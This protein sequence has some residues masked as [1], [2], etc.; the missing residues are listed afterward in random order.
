MPWRHHYLLVLHVDKHVDSEGGPHQAGGARVQER[1]CMWASASLTRSSSARST[2][3]PALPSSTTEARWLRVCAGVQQ[4]PA[5]SGPRNVSAAPTRLRRRPNRQQRPRSTL[6]NNH[7][8]LRPACT[9]LPLG[10]RS[11]CHPNKRCRALLDRATRP[12]PYSHHRVPHVSR[13]CTCLST[14]AML[15]QECRCRHRLSKQ[16]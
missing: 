3:A 8:P 10:S 4:C 15:E 16:V 5:T 14:K 9:C 11:P 6:S 2:S 13:A 1:T 12:P 7:R